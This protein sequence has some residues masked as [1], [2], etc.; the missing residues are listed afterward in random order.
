MGATVMNNSSRFALCIALVFL[1]GPRLFG[2]EQAHMYP[3]MTDAFMAG[4]NQNKFVLIFFH[5]SSVAPHPRTDLMWPVAQRI[6]EEPLI[7]HH[8]VLGDVDLAHDE[9]GAAVARALNQQCARAGCPDG[10]IAGPSISLF[11]PNSKKIA[12]IARLVGVQRD[13]AVRTLLVERM[14]ESVQR[15]DL[16]SPPM[17]D[18]LAGACRGLADSRPSLLIEGWR[19]MDAGANGF[20]V[21]FPGIPREYDRQIEVAGGRVVA[22]F[23]TCENS[24]ETSMLVFIDSDH[25][26]D[27]DGALREYRS[28]L[29]DVGQIESEV[30]VRFAGYPALRYAVAPDMA[31]QIEGIQ[32]VAGRRAYQLLY[33]SNSDYLSKLTAGEFFDSFRL[34]GN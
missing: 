10:G 34:A 23:V 13:Y 24:Q 1:S 2:Q 8:A 5:D 7:Q 4:M 27:P 29:P 31:T 25:N 19:H 28:H 20:S 9:A 33:Q 32:F 22:H 15:R 12:E 17:Y 6:A 30:D 18:E 3:N 16:A 21:D 14:C 26:L 11:L